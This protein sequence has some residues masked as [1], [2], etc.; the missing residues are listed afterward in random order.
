MIG[1]FKAFGATNGLIRRIF[2]YNGLRLVLRGLFLGNLVAL[3]FG[4]IQ[5]YL[6]IIPL[7][8]E[9]YYMDH[10]PIEWNWT[11]T[12]GVNLLTLVIVGIVLIL[13]T[14]LISRIGPVKAIRFD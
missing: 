14:A 6:E 4:V 1:S 13:P 11:V 7:N 5:Y 12:L 3:A 2:T 10:V 8:P 9:T